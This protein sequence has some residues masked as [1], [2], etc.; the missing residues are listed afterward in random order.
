MAYPQAARAGCDWLE[1]GG[2][3]DFVT[4]GGMRCTNRVSENQSRVGDELHND[5]ID[6]HGLRGLWWLARH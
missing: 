5:A 4:A 1:F 6:L 2:W 3:S